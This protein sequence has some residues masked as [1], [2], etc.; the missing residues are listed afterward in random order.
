MCM[1]QIAE[2]ENIAL[3]DD[4]KSKVSKAAEEYYK[5]LSDEEIDFMDIKKSSMEDIQSE[6][7]LAMKLYTTLTKDIKTED[8]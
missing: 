3:D 7:A 8:W 4:E 5:S 6:Y 1:A 2:Q